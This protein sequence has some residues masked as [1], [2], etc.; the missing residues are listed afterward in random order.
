MTTDE[1]ISSS[2][3]AWN[4]GASMLHIH[5]RKEDGEP[6]QQLEYFVPIVKGLREAGC[7]AILNLSTGSAAGRYSGAARYECL[8][9]RPEMGS[10][11]CGSINFGERVFEN[12]AQFLRELA[13]AFLDF[14]V[15]PEI[16]CFDDGQ[17]GN[18][19]RLRE[20]G[21][22]QDPLHF[23]FVLGVHGGAPATIEQVLHMRTMIPADATWSVCSIG[24]GQLPLNMLS[25]IAGG[26]VRTGLEDNIYYHR[27]VIAESNEQLV[28]RIV[29][30][31]DEIGRPVATP[32]QARE[33]LSLKQPSL[34]A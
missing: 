31:A 19:L 28:A 18:A 20:Q 25:L 8:E 3:A 9:L 7:D 30:I 34:A 32:D 27:G 10:L 6:T 14:G 1:I 15:K 16:E 23:Q 24:R 22:L 13:Q 17:I 2:I 11:D 29:R 4:V 12:S 5:A 33:L 21:L 26:H